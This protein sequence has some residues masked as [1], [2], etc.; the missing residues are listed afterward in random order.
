MQQKTAACQVNN[1]EQISLKY[2][3]FRLLKLTLRFIS[4]Y[5][6]VKEESGIDYSV[7]YDCLFFPYN[8]N[9]EDAVLIASDELGY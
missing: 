4:G 9:C 5:N 1:R 7:C 2:K 8:D 6:K 3:Y